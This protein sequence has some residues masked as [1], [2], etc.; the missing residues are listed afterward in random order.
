MNNQIIE[1]EKLIAVNLQLTSQLRNEVDNKDLQIIDQLKEIA[2]QIIDALDSFERVETNLIEKGLANKDEILKVMT[3]YN[4][5]KKKLSKC[6]SKYGIT[7]IEFPDNRLIV[8][9]CEVVDTEADDKRQNDE[10][11]TVVA[12]GYIRGKELI[13]AAQV[14][15]VKN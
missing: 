11:V 1:L 10:I 6:L 3:R 15:V 13:R 5:I 12:N 9:L 7:Q 4:A 14:I 8:G 2:L